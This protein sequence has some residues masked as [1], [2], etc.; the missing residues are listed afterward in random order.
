[1]IND[2]LDASKLKA[3]KTALTTEPVSLQREVE[4]VVFAFQ[5]AKDQSTGE[6]LVAPGTTLRS[7][8]PAGLGCVLAD[9]NR[10]SQ[11]LYNTIGNAC[12]FTEKGLVRV[13]A[14]ACG[15]PDGGAGTGWLAVSIADTGSGISSQDL[16][17]IFEEYGQ[18]TASSGGR[19]FTG[20]G[21]GLSI[22]KEL[23]VLHGGKIWVE[24]T[25]GRGT[26]FT[27]TL[28]CTEEADSDGGGEDYRPSEGTMDEM[29][30]G[31]DSM[32]HGP[33]TLSLRYGSGAGLYDRMRTLLRQ[34]FG[35]VGSGASSGGGTP[36]SGP[37]QARGPESALES[38]SWYVGRLERDDATRALAKQPIG[39][40]IVRRGTRGYVI[41]VRYARD[42][43]EKE[44][45]EDVFHV[46]I[47]QDPDGAAFWVA[48]HKK[49]GTVPNLVAHYMENSSLFFENLGGARAPQ[50]EKLTPARL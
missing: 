25:L 43:S 36:R 31:S 9:R 17:A 26:T 48:E 14:R 16:D 50:G 21:L 8:V 45:R 5:K 33:S 1:M 42:A 32:M 30:G 4:R 11:I 28:P 18:A 34:Q 10:L 35:E 24:S 2:I 40:F 49:F 22:C 39:A 27:F 37:S 23:V 3:G 20:T 15:Q 13:T 6:P 19:E 38:C 41:S 29:F 44:Q 7:D 46:A 12:K 47:G